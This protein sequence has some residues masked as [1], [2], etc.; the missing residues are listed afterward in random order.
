MLKSILGR[1]TFD[2]GHSEAKIFGPAATLRA[3][4]ARQ[5]RFSDLKDEKSWKHKLYG[6]RTVLGH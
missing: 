6:D 1:R 4:R 5:A 2:G 3:A